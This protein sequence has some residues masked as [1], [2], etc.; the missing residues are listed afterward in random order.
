MRAC[1][2]GSQSPTST[3]LSRFWLLGSKYERETD[4]KTKTDTYEFTGF[5]LVLN[6]AYLA[7]KVS[8]TD[9]M[10]EWI[11]SL[12]TVIH[13]LSVFVL[14]TNNQTTGLVMLTFDK[15]K[16][17]LSLQIHTLHSTF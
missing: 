11:Y 4:P 14:E 3:T 9:S 17:V 1:A 2:I 12:K 13:F 10:T 5:S 16:Q 8:D 6:V 7:I 15:L